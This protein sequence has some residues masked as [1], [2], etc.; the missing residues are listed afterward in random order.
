MYYLDVSQRARRTVRGGEA[1]HQGSPPSPGGP[2]LL[3]GTLPVDFLVPHSRNTSLLVGSVVVL[4]HTTWPVPAAW[5]PPSRQRTLLSAGLAMMG[6]ENPSNQVKGD[7]WSWKTVYRDFSFF[8][9][10][11]RWSV[12]TANAITAS[13]SSGKS[14]GTKKS[15]MGS[16]SPLINA[17][18]SAVAFHPLSV[19]KVRKRVPYLA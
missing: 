10:F 5:V 3:L 2:S 19:A 6:E 4:P 1:A 7:L 14:R 11:K 12:L 13:R 16:E 8:C 17:S 15:C 18:Y 9:S